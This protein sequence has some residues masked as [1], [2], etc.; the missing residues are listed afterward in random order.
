MPVPVTR[1]STGGRWDDVKGRENSEKGGDM[2]MELL[3]P[4]KLENAFRLQHPSWRYFF[5]MTFPKVSSTRLPTTKSIAM[6][7]LHD[8]GSQFELPKLVIASY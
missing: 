2:A 7:H 8:T 3:L 1:A 5:F 6:W 4:G